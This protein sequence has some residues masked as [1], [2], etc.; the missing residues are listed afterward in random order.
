MTPENELENDPENE[1]LNDFLN[2]VQNDLENEGNR[3]SD[4]KNAEENENPFLENAEKMSVEN[5]SKMDVENA[6]EM[7]DNFE[8]DQEDFE[9]EFDFPEDDFEDDPLDD[10]I[11]G[12]AEEKPMDDLI[13]E[14]TGDSVKNLELLEELGELAME[15]IDDSKAML[16]SAISGESPARYASDKKLNKALLKAFANYLRSNNV[17]APS[18]LGSLLLVLAMWGLPTLGAAFFHRS[19]AKKAAKK[20]A[21]KKVKEAAEDIEDVEIEGESQSDTPDKLDYTHLKEYQEN[22]RL[23]DIHKETG[24]YNRTPK[25]QFCKTSLAKEQPSP[26]IQE[27]LSE[28]LTNA[29][30]R[31]RI[32]NE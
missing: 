24:C 16:C 17:K 27:M 12:E 4:G 26:E 14:I 25:G 8:D 5:D 21:A 29:A 22:R 7:E 11:S 15:K 32:Y 1:I 13:S 23:F 3:I 18:P 19:Q 20:Q 9:D 28:G 30:I 2:G 10:A 6:D 31:E